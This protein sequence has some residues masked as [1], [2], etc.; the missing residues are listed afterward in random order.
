LN[1]KLAE[2]LFELGLH[3][4]EAEEHAE[5]K[6]YLEEAARLDTANPLIKRAAEKSAALAPASADPQKPK[7]PAAAKAR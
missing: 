6:K 3:L 1:R 5:A 7:G 4:Q 2:R